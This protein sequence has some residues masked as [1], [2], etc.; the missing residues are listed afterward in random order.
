MKKSIIIMNFTG[1][2]DREDFYKDY[3][4]R[5]L[6][7]TDL[8]GTVGYCSD[9]AAE[10][11]RRRIARMP[12]EAVHF[13]DSGNYHYLSGFWIEKIEEPFDL[14][15][16]D[17]HTDMKQPALGNILSC[18]SWILE[19]I[20]HLPMLHKVYLL[21]ADESLKSTIDPDCEGRYEMIPNDQ[22]LTHAFWEQL[23]KNSAA[24]RYPLYIS[25]DKDVLS[26]KLIHTDWDQGDMELSTMKDVLHEASHRQRILGIDICGEPAE[27][28]PEYD[29]QDNNELNHNIADFILKLW[30]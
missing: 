15:V 11:I 3:F 22:I 18:G 4:H 13:L 16:M 14:L 20:R 9:D 6:D 2:Y 26:Q 27:N 25:I 19:A 29:I 8:R 1:V 17:H 24:N 21:G 10:E 7:F 12:S 28:A 5:Y 30:K 23:E